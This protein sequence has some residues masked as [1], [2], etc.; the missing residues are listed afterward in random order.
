[1]IIRQYKE[2]D[3]RALAELFYNTVHTVCADD[4]TTEQLDA[5]ASGDVDF[6]EWNSSLSSHY[7]LVALED[8]IVVGFGDIAAGSNEV[9]GSMCGAYLDRLY[10]HKDYQKKGIASS[11]C[12]A[13]EEYAFVRLAE[14]SGNGH[15]PMLKIV[16]HA[17]LTA[18]PFFEKRG[19]IVV[20]KQEVLKNN[21]TLTNFVMEK[22]ENKRHFYSASCP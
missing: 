22:T 21:V 5:W 16:T 1:M 11:L 10:V 2:N 8:G 15:E 12:D 17:S 4:Y 3:C 20:K 19:Y 7:S 9:L 13:L 6:D 14:Y 18:K